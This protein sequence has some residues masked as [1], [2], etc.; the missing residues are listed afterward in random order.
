MAAAMHAARIEHSDRLQRV[1][2]LLADGRPRTT[3]DIVTEAR[4]CAVNSIAAELRANGV[5]VV[6]QRQGDI[7][8][9]WIEQE[10]RD[11]QPA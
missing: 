1:L 9:Y 4:V 6:C 2:A 7:W 3:L 5:P 8:W 10:S 11:E